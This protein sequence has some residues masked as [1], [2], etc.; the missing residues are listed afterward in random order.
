MTSEPYRFSLAPGPRWVRLPLDM[1]ASEGWQDEMAGR[2]LPPEASADLRTDLAQQLVFWL[3]DCRDRGVP[4]ALALVPDRLATVAAVAELYT[5]ERDPRQ[6]T[7]EAIEWL[8]ENLT[9]DQEPVKGPPVRE[10]IEL[11]AGPAV[12][13]RAIYTES[14]DQEGSGVLVERVMHAVLP[15]QIPDM[16][17]LSTTWAML[18]LGEELAEQADE[19]ARTLSV[20]A[21]T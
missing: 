1:D 12:R 21:V 6:P 18:A 16:V 10:A 5:Y 9:A 14:P 4:S 13:M 7:A 15:P 11:P 8:R 3:G 20:K 17:L 19:L 2:L